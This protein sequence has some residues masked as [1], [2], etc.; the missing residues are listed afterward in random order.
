MAGLPWT[1]SSHSR[2]PETTIQPLQALSVV[3]VQ[4]RVGMQGSPLLSNNRST[5]WR[6]IAGS[7]STPTS[8]NPR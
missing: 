4:V 6:T 7:S 2:L 1:G 5:R 3:G 8:G